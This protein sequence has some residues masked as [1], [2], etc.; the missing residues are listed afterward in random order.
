MRRSFAALA[1]SVAV[2]G[3][4]VVALP[5]ASAAGP[6]CSVRYTVVGQ[7]AG[8]FQGDVQVTNLGDPI[9]SW[10]V[11]FDFAD[12]AQKVSQGWSAQWSQ[13]GARVAASSYSWNGALGTNASTSVGFIGSWSTSNPPATR[14]TLNGVGCNLPASPLPSAT[15]SS[16]PSPS[17]SPSAPSPSVSP[18]PPPTPPGTVL[19]QVHTPGRVTAAG[20]VVKYSWPGIYFEARVRGTGFGI[21]LD[22]SANDY[23]VQVDGAT[24]K[25]LVTPAK[26]THWVNGLT[27][28]AHAVRLVKRSESPWSTS[29]FG[30]FVA[31]PGG[32]I[33]AKP[34]ARSRQI[35]FIGD[36]NT[37][38]YGNTSG[39]RDCEGDTVNRTTN[40]DRSFGAITA[41]ALNAD[42]Q[43]NA[44]SG[45]GMVRNYNGGSPEVNYRTSYDRALLDVDGDVW[46]NPGTWRPQLVVIGLGINDFS[47]PVNPGEQWTSETLVTAYRSAYL[48]FI[49]KLR[50]RYGTST[51][52][53][54]SAATTPGTPFA[55]AAQQV[56]AD[57]NDAGDARVRYWSYGESGMDNMGCH[58]H[59]SAQDHQT[60]A[61]RLGAFV[62]TL[63]LGW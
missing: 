16:A 36:S 57:R 41:K 26:G 4:A 17:V 24:V 40:A 2:A 19:D 48:G 31:A 52:I 18:T 25:T 43:I 49:D 5:Q 27:D 30:G 39:T 6:G 53:I 58:W 61:D 37:A 13:S 46:R 20:D 21:V 12:A 55:Q 14:F 28:A 35:E 10:T 7:W 34:A 22:D 9:S 3:L 23:D 63:P 1:A 59:P 50:A 42:Y 15:P 33:L 44:I 54:V 8:G 60:I 47:T 56:V 32:A 62:A 45:R 29:A 11:G 51:T 38:G